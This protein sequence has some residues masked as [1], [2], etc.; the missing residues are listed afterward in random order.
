MI[1]TKK[2][3]S[4]KMYLR[5]RNMCGNFINKNDTIQGLYGL[6]GPKWINIIDKF[7]WWP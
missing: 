6:I 4:K 1:K 7:K 3:G 5:L 2:E